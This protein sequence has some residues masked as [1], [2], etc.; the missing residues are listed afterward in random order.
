[1]RRLV[2]ELPPPTPWLTR[3]AIGLSAIG[4]S[5]VAL[6]MTGP[7][8]PALCSSIVS[9]G[10]WSASAV[11]AWWF[12]NPPIQLAMGWLW[13][14][15]AMMP[16]MLRRPAAHVWRQSLHRRRWSAVAA[17]AS[18]Y[19][20]TWMIAGVPLLAAVTVVLWTGR[21]RP[22]AAFVAVFVCVLAWQA[23]PRR[24]RSFNR[25]HRQPT[26]RAFGWHAYGDAFRFGS[27]HALS[28]IALCGPW[29]LLA[30]IAGAGHLPAMVATAVLMSLERD[31]P[32]SPERWQWPFQ[33][34]FG[35]DRDLVR[36]PMQRT[37]TTGVP[38]HHS[39]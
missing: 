32:G 12:A 36:T 31:R 28:C 23:S 25:C 13:M 16:P 10:Y 29:M 35:R 27:S 39:I 26:L 4:W 3:I 22:E 38:P 8:L 11:Q 6:T 5:C 33:A 7:T 37:P 17:F 1:M 34:L 18:G 15:L 21:E 14:L 30:L 24:Q 19:F 20:T 9:T 2:A